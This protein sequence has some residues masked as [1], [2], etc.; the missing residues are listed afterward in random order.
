MTTNSSVV[1]HGWCTFLYTSGLPPPNHVFPELMNR[2]REVGNVLTCPE[3]KT[4]KVILVVNKVGVCAQFSKCNNRK[5]HERS[6]TT[7]AALS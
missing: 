3:C 1:F 7:F 5:T 2:Q 6:A 4:D